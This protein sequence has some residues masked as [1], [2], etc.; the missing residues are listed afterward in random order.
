M[1]DKRKEE[2]PLVIF[3]SLVMIPQKGDKAGTIDFKTKREML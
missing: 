2:P 3:F 1:S